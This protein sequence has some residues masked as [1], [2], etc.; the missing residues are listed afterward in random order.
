LYL[1]GINY[2]NEIGDKMA[3][4]IIEYFNNSNNINII[5]ECLSSNL[6][7]DTLENIKTTSLTDNLFVFTGTLKKYSRSEAI[8]I[9]E[10]FGASASINKKTNYLVA[11]DKSGSKLNKAK[12]LN[13]KILN[14]DEFLNL[15][16]N[17]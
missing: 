17:I 15:I 13:I 14:E 3:N 9:I 10:S 4:S 16:N 6:E 12:S 7:F 11:G 1:R 5:N 8:K 2:I